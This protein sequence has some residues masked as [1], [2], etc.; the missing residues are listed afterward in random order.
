M[1]KIIT[2]IIYFLAGIASVELLTV[3]FSLMNQQSTVSFWSGLAIIGVVS[4]F[5]GVAFYN[6]VSQPLKN[7]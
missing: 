7:K 3:G 1:K 4:T 6:L 2:G 5:I